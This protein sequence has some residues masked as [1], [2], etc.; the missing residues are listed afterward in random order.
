MTTDQ[1]GWLPWIYLASQGKIL[2]VNGHSVPDQKHEEDV[3][4]KRAFPQEPNAVPGFSVNEKWLG[5]DT[6][7]GM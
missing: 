6:R 3:H 4:P 1:G 5:K 7:G 2:S